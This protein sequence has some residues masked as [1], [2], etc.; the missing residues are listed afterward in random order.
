MVKANGLI[1]I[2]AKTV[3]NQIMTKKRFFVFVRGKL[4]PVYFPQGNIFPTKMPIGKKILSLL[5]VR[6][7]LVGSY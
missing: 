4:M 1:N 5:V 3:P 7:L 6:K 2:L